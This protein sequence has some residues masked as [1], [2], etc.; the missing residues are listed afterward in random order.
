[1]STATT[2]K[3]DIYRKL[4]KL[5]AFIE[6]DCGQETLNAINLAETIC[7]KYGITDFKYTPYWNNPNTSANDTNSTKSEQKKANREQ[8]RSDNDNDANKEWLIISHTS[9]MRTILLNYLKIRGLVFR[10][11]NG[12]VHVLAAQFQHVSILAE[13]EQ[14]KTEWKKRLS[15]VD[16]IMYSWMNARY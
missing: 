2:N 7:K 15:E 8:R 3:T 14:I 6:R 1:M 12:K 13:I 9:T 10:T 16:N 4:E 11:E 5:R